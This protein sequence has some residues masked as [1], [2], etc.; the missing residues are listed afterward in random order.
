M[1][2]LLLVDVLLYSTVAE[3]YSVLEKTDELF[4]TLI[5]LHENLLTFCF[6]F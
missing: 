1:L 6:M 3:M 5:L 4:R 2:P